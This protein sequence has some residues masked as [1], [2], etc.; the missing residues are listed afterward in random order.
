MWLNLYEFETESY[1]LIESIRDNYY[2]VAIIDND[3][4]SANDSG[5]SSLWQAM[6]DVVK[7]NTTSAA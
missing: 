3:Y 7:N 4:V 6:L 1:D 2:L 5:E